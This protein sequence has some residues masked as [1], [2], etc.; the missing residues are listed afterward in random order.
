MTKI[1]SIESCQDESSN[2]HNNKGEKDMDEKFF[3][4][5]MYHELSLM[6]ENVQHI[7]DEL[8]EFKSSVKE[9]KEILLN[10]ENGV[11]IRLRDIE[12]IKSSLAKW[13]WGIVLAISGA[14]AI[15]LFKLIF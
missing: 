12:K 2:G 5:P 14:G 11:I 10:T 6:N 1:L 13:V 15:S 7:K 9:I 4:C 3:Q 8:P